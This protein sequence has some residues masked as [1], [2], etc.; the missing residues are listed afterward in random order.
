MRVMVVGSGG[1]EHALAWKI[2][3]SPLVRDLFCMPGNAGTAAI[4]E[5]IPGDVMDI[6][7]VVDIAKS[8]RIDLAVVG[9][10]APLAIG[11]VNAL[12]AKG[13]AAFGP[14]KDAAAIESSKLFSKML[15]AAAGI[16]TAKFAA[17]DVFD[18]AKSHIDGKELPVIVKADGLAAGKGVFVCRSREDVDEAL[19]KTLLQGEFGEAGKRIIVEE[20]LPGQ[21][22]SMV[23]ITDG[24]VMLPLPGSE[25]HKQLL[26][27]DKGPNTG[28]M[29]A[30]SPTEVLHRSMR[31]RVMDE[32]MYPAIRGLKEQGIIY[33]GALYAGLMILGG[34]PYVLEFNCRFG[35]PETQ[36][37]LPRLKG[38]IVP[39]LMA[40]AK[41]SLSDM[42]LEVE[43]NHCVCVTL[44]SDGYPGSYRKGLEI[45]GLDDCGKLD[46][47]VLFHAGTKSIG[48]KILTSGGRVLG[49]T[50]LGSDKR[51]AIEL[52]Y[53]AVDLVRFDG[54][55]FRRD[56][57]LRR[58]DK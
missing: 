21:E 43:N 25:D 18:A 38:D 16:R 48:G 31:D 36:A 55:H 8:N 11:L 47:V 1:R 10:E 9:P 24:E 28:G 54:R 42:E 35:D 12:E 29:G 27:G 41:G 53:K 52:C 3:Q 14:N 5:N 20:F 49:V 26:D 39:I 22:A 23:A 15:M 46:D 58:G 2:K 19:Q 37:T 45:S 50:A 57:G 34:D 40:A 44:A 32:I 51:K 33:R 6:E 17:F 56:I 7:R 30:F 4:A 13:I